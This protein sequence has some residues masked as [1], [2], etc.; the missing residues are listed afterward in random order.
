MSTF[1]PPESLEPS[2]VPLGCQKWGIDGGDYAAIF[3]SAH[4]EGG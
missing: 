4:A 3:E 2:D 1:A